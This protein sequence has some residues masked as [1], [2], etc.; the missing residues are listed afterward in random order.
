MAKVLSKSEK[1]TNWYNSP[2]GAM[3]QSEDFS[4]KTQ[5]TS[6][7]SKFTRG[8]IQPSETSSVRSGRNGL[9][10]NGEKLRS[11][12]C[13]ISLPSSTDLLTPGVGVIL[14]HMLA[15]VGMRNP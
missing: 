12:I 10:K 13:Y 7:L 2:E 5:K 8:P 6:F 11:N 9:K 3:Q 1:L 14:N 4:A 15:G